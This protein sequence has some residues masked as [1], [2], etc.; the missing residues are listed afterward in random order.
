MSCITFHKI[1]VQPY[2]KMPTPKSWAYYHKTDDCIAKITS[3]IKDESCSR[4][5]LEY[6]IIST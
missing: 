1:G 5:W 4:I 3:K 2:A 6:A